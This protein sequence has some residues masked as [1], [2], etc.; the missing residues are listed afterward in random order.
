[1][2]KN[3]FP[4]PDVL[5]GA[6]RDNDSGISG[7]EKAV[8]RPIKATIPPHNP[9]FFCHEV[10][11]VVPGDRYHAVEQFRKNIVRLLFLLCSKEYVMITCIVF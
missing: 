4:P 6:I 2:R 1:M 10:K 5:P 8:I 11:C 7:K 9:P 3:Q